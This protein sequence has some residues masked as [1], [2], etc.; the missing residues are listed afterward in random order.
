MDLVIGNSKKSAI[1]S[2]DMVKFMRIACIIAFVVMLGWTGTTF[3]LHYLAV[4]ENEEVQAEIDKIKDIEDIAK[5]YEDAQILFAAIDT[6]KYEK[7]ND[8]NL[9]PQFFDDLEKILPKGTTVESIQ[10]DN[11]DVRLSL[12][13]D[14]HPTTKNEVADVIVQINKLDYTSNLQLPDLTEEQAIR[15]MSPSIDK[16]ALETLGDDVY[17]R[18]K[19]DDPLYKG[20]IIEVSSRAEL[21]DLITNL[22]NH[23]GTEKYPPELTLETVNDMAVNLVQTKYDVTVHI[24]HDYIVEERVNEEAGFTGDKAIVINAVNPDNN[25]TPADGAAP[26][27]PAAEEED[28]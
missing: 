15:F 26:E 13:S 14:W 23:E 25:S 28:M 20:H 12:K 11:G 24:G 22:A 5:A 2:S 9:L 17:L 3:A 7:E 27:A 6:F 10:A 19:S 8:N 16:A 21:L 18:E 4:K 1:E